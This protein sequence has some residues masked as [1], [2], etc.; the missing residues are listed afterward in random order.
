MVEFTENLRRRCRKCKGKL[1]TPASNER[2]AF[3]CRGCYEQFYRTRCRVCECAI[4]QPK[5][6]GQR[7]ICKRARCKSDWE[8]KAGFGR[9]LASKKQKPGRYPLSDKTISESLDFIASKQRTEGR[10]WRTIAG[11]ALSP[12]ALHAATISDGPDMEWR[13]GQY[14]GVEARNKDKLR[15]HFK[16]QAE[17]CLIQA[18]HAPIDVV[19]GYRFSGAPQLAP[20]PT[21]VPNTLSIGEGLDIHEFLRRAPVTA[22]APDH[23]EDEPS[24]DRVAA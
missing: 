11:P 14:E 10:R 3:C 18:H 19:G 5:V 23:P 7:V 2:E 20:H 1:P 21:A 6:G 17:K 9:F 8:E 16:A 15:K 4:E 24:V 22:H 12:A 13:G